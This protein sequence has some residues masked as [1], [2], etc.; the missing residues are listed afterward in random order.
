MGS[1]Q[2]ITRFGDNT[3]GLSKEALAE[4]NRVYGPLSFEERIARVFEDF[5]PERIMVTSSFAATS[6]YFLHIISTIRPGLPD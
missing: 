6:A 4:L 5:S 3:A 1:A 2:L